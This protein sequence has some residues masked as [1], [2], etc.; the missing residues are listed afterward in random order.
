MTQQLQFIPC[1]KSYK[2]EPYVM[3]KRTHFV[4]MFDERFINYGKDK[5]SWIEHLRYS[6]YSFAVLRN[7]FAIDI[8]HP[9]YDLLICICNGIDQ[10]LPK[11]SLKPKRRERMRSGI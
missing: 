8:P 6:G 9:R 5:I 4:P 2:Q 7:A 11:S 3:V 1:F 10:N